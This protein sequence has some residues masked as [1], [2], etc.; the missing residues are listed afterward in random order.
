MKRIIISFIALA[1]GSL[2]MACSTTSEIEALR[3]DIAAIETLPD[4]MRF[5]VDNGMV[6]RMSAFVE[7]TNVHHLVDREDVSEFERNFYHMIPYSLITEERVIQLD[8]E[9]IFD[10]FVSDF[11]E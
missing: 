2:L 9:I 10:V 8:E 11:E 4:R 3:N 1:L 5:A 7:D 6:I